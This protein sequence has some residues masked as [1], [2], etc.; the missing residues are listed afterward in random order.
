MKFLVL[1][2]AVLV[3]AV[4]VHPV[5]LNADTFAGAINGD[6]PAFVKFYAPCACLFIV[7]SRD[8]R[9]YARC[10]GSQR[11]VSCMFTYT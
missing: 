6:K 2:A 1:L 4:A 3:V 5:E 9:S 11:M 10:F 8:L 7:W